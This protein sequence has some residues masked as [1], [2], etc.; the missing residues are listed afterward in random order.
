MVPRAADQAAQGGPHAQ[1]GGIAERRIARVVGTQAPNARAGFRAC[2]PARVPACEC[3]TFG[4]QAALCR[5]GLMGVAVI[6][7]LERAASIHAGAGLL[8]VLP[9]AVVHGG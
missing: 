4:A 6:A 1:L 5:L 9:L 2:W 7:D 3:T 8:L